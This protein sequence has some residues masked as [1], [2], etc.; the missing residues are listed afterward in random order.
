[1]FGQYNEAISRMY[2]S[3]SSIKPLP[4]NALKRITSE[5]KDFPKLCGIA[6]EAVEKYKH[7]VKDTNQYSSNQFFAI[8]TLFGCAAYDT[9]Y[10]ALQLADT[11]SLMKALK[12][13]PEN[14]AIRNELGEADEASVLS[15]YRP[16]S[17][18]QKNFLG[19]DQVESQIRII[20]KDYPTLEIL[21][22]IA[23]VTKGCPQVPR[24]VLKKIYAP[25]AEL[26][27][28]VEDDG[29]ECEF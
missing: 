14:L 8:T 16:K 24:R 7:A 29:K 10:A 27:E 25:A 19:K 4:D 15:S 6:E 28:S 18:I 20:M 9:A 21:D 26:M 22:E 11:L 2:Y 12:A 5:L 1:M 17:K 13:N 3:T 23:T